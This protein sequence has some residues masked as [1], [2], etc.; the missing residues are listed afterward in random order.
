MAEFDL[1]KLICK[2]LIKFLLFST[3]S[4]LKV[5]MDTSQKMDSVVNLGP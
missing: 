2:T 1:F 3:D 4:G 5:T